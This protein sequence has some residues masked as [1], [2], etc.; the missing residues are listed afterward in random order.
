MTATY[1]DYL[2]NF[3]LGAKPEADWLRDFRLKAYGK[4]QQIGLPTRKTEAWKYMNLE[5]VLK[6]AFA[7]PELFR[8]GRET[9]DKHF[10]DN[11]VCC[12]RN[13]TPNSN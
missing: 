6:T 9:I 3:K 4:F 10:F 2:S 12:I 5:P 11:F 8:S 1:Q 7:K 13:C